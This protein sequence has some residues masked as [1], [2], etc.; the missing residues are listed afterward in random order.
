MKVDVPP[1]A[2]LAV[3]HP[4]LL[5]TGRGAILLNKSHVRNNGAAG[6]AVP[7]M[8]ARKRH[9]SF[10]RSTSGEVEVMLVESKA[11]CWCDFSFV[12]VKLCPGGTGD[13]GARILAST[14]CPHA[15]GSKQLRV[16]STNRQ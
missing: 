2:S 9:C 14:R 13:P 3:P 4:C 11:L 15:S 16:G 8:G 10:V 6:A 5:A 12:R 1:H 7:N